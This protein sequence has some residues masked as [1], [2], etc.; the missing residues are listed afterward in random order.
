MQLDLQAPTIGLTPLAK[1]LLTLMDH[2]LD[3]ME[4]LGANGVVQG[5]SAGIKSVSGYDPEDLV[6]RQYQE[7]I[8]PDDC[9][10]AS[11]AFA[12]A[13][14]G[15]PCEAVQLRYL[16]KGG[17]WRTMLASAR[18]FLEDPAIRAIVFLTRD[19]TAQCAAESKL[20]LANST[21]ARLTAESRGAE[22][23][24][25]HYLAAELH[26]DVQQILVG[27]RMGMAPSQ[28]LP[29]DR[30][31][32][33]LVADWIEL[34]QKAIEH[35]H[36]L[37]V[38][39]RT[40]VVTDRGLPDA[41]RSHVDHVRMSP[42]QRIAFEA[43][44]NLGTV[45]PNVALACFRIVQEG[46][47][48]AITHSRATNLRVGLKCVDGYLIV[49]IVDDGVGFD[50]R[51]AIARATIVGRVGLSSMRERVASAGGRFEIETAVG[52]GTKIVAS[53]PVEEMSAPAR[54]AH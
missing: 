30:V 32:S 52:E 5:V 10:R 16:Q 13:L 54:S 27:L 28:R 29:V 26:D 11:K 33:E 7:I 38:G 51:D 1:N 37:A 17:S 12:R 34:L 41:L 6:G 21:V 53:F 14:K 50:L 24:Q 49:S 45:A 31:P 19:V 3:F 9:G 4:V 35:I 36:A 20:A 46:L 22:E 25:R 23:R 47:A 8:H 40:P 15:K 43:D 48:N 2:G 39:L 18:S 42:S 44:D